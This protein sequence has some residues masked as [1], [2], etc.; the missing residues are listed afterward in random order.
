MSTYIISD[1]HGCNQAFR[2]ALKKVKLKKVDTLILLGDL[3]DRGPDSKEVL[4]TVL[5]LIE[6]GFKVICLKGNHEQMMLDSLDDLTS[7]VNWIKNGGKETLKS[8]LTSEVERIP[9]KYIDF[10]KTFKSHFIYKNFILVHAGINMTLEDPFSDLHSLLWLRNWENVYNAEWL[11]NRIVIHG[12]TPMKSDEIKTQFK[13]G[14]KVICIDNGS[15]VKNN[16]EFG[17][18]CVLKIDDLSFHFE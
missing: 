13:K 3:I 12:H 7:K 4:D 18:I 2:R 15:Y 5:L 11:N 1:I 16:Q 10:L 14:H 8:F 17:S 9:Q 6:H